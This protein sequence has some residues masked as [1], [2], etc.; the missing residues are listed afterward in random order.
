MVNV[1]GSIEAGGRGPGSSTSSQP[2]EGGSRYTPGA[3]A[4]LAGPPQVWI[5]TLTRWRIE[6]GLDSFVLWPAQGDPIGQIELFANEI[7]PA[8]RAAIGE[9]TPG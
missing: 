1:S 3:D 7:A 9:T 6:R 2:A 4:G 8:V 5:E